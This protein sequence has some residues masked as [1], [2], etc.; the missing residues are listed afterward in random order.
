MK[1]HLKVT[2][3]W[4]KIYIQA[5]KRNHR[6][7]LVSTSIGSTWYNPQNSRV[8]ETSNLQMHFFPTSQTTIYLTGKYAN[9]YKNYCFQKDD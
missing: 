6:S 3:T 2:L 4:N 1:D 7:N 9:I 8:H 5:L